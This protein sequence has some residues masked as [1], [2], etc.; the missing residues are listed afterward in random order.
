MKTSIDYSVVL[1]LLVKSLS[2]QT[3]KAYQDDVEYDDPKF[4]FSELCPLSYRIVKIV[5]NSSDQILDVKRSLDE[6]LFDA[7]EIQLA[8]KSGINSTNKILER[9]ERQFE[10]IDSETVSRDQKSQQEILSAQWELLGKV[11]LGGKKLVSDISDLLISKIEEGNRVLFESLK[12]E[13]RNLT[14]PILSDFNGIKQKVEHMEK[15]FLAMQNTTNFALEQMKNLN[16]SKYY[17]KLN[18]TTLSSGKKY[19]LGDLKVTWRDAKYFCEENNMSLASVKT[20]REIKLLWKVARI[21][22]ESG[23]WLSASDIGR[24]PGQFVWRGGVKVSRDRDWWAKNEP[25]D[26]GKG[27]EAC[28]GVFNDSL[29][30]DPCHYTAHFICE[31]PSECF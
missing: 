6:K 14:G 18:V 21:D 23:S 30:S 26:F 28:V 10:K 11:E 12:K 9:F 3:V 19:Y 4:D 27:Q 24:T 2:F 1:L 15:D 29:F 16:C 13:I 17:E 22:K 7:K 20:K 5:R 31:L 25:N 8:V